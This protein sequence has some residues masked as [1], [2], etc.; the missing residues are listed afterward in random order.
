MRRHHVWG[1]PVRAIRT[2]GVVLAS[3]VL[4]ITGPAAAQFTGPECQIN[5]FTAGDQ[6]YPAVAVNAAKARSLAASVGL[7]QL[8]FTNA[9]VS[10]TFA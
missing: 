7:S 4:L 10:T 5:T 6:A 9:S 3:G 1:A 8:F 2:I